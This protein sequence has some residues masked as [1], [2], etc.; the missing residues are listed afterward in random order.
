MDEELIDELLECG[1]TIWDGGKPPIDRDVLVE[2]SCKD[3]PLCSGIE[4][5][6]NLEWG[7]CCGGDNIVAYK[8]VSAEI[9]DGVICNG[10]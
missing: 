5:A 8:T 2:Y 3:N 10:S 1:F 4:F 9:C 7:S 6:R